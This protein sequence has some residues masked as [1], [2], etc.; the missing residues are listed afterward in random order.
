MPIAVPS[1][2]LFR[3]ACAQ[4]ATGVAVS[5]VSDDSGTPHGLTINSFTSVSQDP[6]LILICIDFRA[7]IL[8][9]FLHAKHF[10]LSFLEESQSE[11]SVRFSR[12]TDNRFDGV[13]WHAGDT[14]APLIE[15]ALATLECAID[16]VL[17]GGDH[18]IFLAHVVRAWVGDGNPLLF[19]KSGYRRMDR[20]SGGGQ[21]PID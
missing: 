10:G 18:T 8:P 4:F 3:R 17:D 13:L 20:E 19:F 15:G 14:G 2:D 5:A 7:A 6:P 11:L 1:P 9:H 12:K 21:K 16:Q